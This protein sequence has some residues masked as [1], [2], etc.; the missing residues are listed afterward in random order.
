MS[1][2]WVA[3]KNTATLE[4][5]SGTGMRR[6]S[7]RLVNI[8]RDGA[9]IAT[10]GASRPQGPLWIRLD[11]PVKTDWIGAVAV[12][13]DQSHRIGLRFF[14]PCPDD[15]LLAAMLGIDLGPTILGFDK[16]LSLDD[17]GVGV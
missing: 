5:E 9:L 13:C 17:V 3:V 14:S 10:E 16:P 8:S 4:F 7:V 2:R 6:L 12:R 1:P 15:F 11:D